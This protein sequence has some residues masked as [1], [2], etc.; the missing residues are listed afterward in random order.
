MFVVY[1]SRRRAEELSRPFAADKDEQAIQ[2]ENIH[3][4]DYRKPKKRPKNVADALIDTAE[5]SVYPTFRNSNLGGNVCSSR[6]ML[7]MA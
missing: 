7:H 5:R 3:K 4:R 6:K 2:A 1:T